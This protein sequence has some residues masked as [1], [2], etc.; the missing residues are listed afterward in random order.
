MLAVAGSTGAGKVGQR[1]MKLSASATESIYKSQ[2]FYVRAAFQCLRMKMWKHEVKPHFFVVVSRV[3]CS[4]WSW[5]SWYHQKV[6]SGT[7]AASPSHRRLPGS[8]QGPFETTS[9]LAWLTTSTA[10]PLSSRPVSW[11]RYIHF[12]INFPSSLHFLFWSWS[13]SL[14]IYFNLFAHINYTGFLLFIQDIIK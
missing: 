1:Q 5:E 12:I 13:G 3:P 14:F 2:V 9:C 11:R 6:K 7:A 8:C 4:W 10:T